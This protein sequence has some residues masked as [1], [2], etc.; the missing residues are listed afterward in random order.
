MGGQALGYRRGGS[1]FQ[2]FTEPARRAVV[3]AEKEAKHLNHDHIGPEHILL[4]L[5]HEGEG[6]AAKALQT[7]GISLEEVRRQVEETIGGGES[8]SPIRVPFS[9]EAKKVFELSAREVIRL[10]H[11]YIGTEHLLLGLVHESECVAAQLLVELG[12]DLDHLRTL[13]P[14]IDPQADPPGVWRG[15]QEGRAT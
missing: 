4:G 13:M 6:V 12:A 5:V 11:Y 9:P 7:V 14:R 10:G 1:V 3:L 15:K 2:R 8:S